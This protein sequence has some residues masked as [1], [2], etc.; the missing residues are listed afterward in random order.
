MQNTTVKDSNV[1]A[2]DLVSHRLFDW[3]RILE[4]EKTIEPTL[5]LAVYLDMIDTYEKCGMCVRDLAGKNFQNR[6]PWSQHIDLIL[7]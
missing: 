3:I 5:L 7:E 1:S 6:P 2:M 4:T